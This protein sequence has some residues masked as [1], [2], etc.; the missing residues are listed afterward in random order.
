MHIGLVNVFCIQR[1]VGLVHVSVEIFS[2]IEVAIVE[3]LT[4]NINEQKES[5]QTINVNEK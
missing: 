4:G 1:T 3:Q 5:W 2:G